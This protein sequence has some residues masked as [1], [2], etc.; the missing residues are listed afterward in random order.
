MTSWFN[1]K[2]SPQNQYTWWAWPRLPHTQHC[3]S[4][5]YTS[6]NLFMW[7]LWWLLQETSFTC[8]GKEFGGYYAD[9]EMDCQAYHIC[10]MVCVMVIYF[11]G[12]KFDGD[13]K[14]IWNKISEETN[15]GLESMEVSC[16]K[17]E[18]LIVFWG[19]AV[20][21]VGGSWLLRG[22]ERTINPPW[23]TTLSFPSRLCNL[24]YKS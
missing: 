23:I 6:L 11:R 17:S 2:L 1:T 7:S 14:S 18:K 22:K 24:W 21:R 5:F 15:W 19:D 4:G 16:L 8:D 3:S 12:L 20:G 10:L 13:I 9:P